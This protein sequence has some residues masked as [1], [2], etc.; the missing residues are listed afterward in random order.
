MTITES[1]LADRAAAAVQAGCKPRCVFKEQRWLIVHG[2]L[3]CY[4]SVAG[5]VRKKANPVIRSNLDIDP[6]VAPVFNASAPEQ[7]HLR[8][9]VVSDD[10]SDDFTDDSNS[11]SSTSSHEFRSSH[12]DRIS[13]PNL[14]R[15]RHSCG[16]VVSRRSCSRRSVPVDR[17][18]DV[19][20]VD[21]SSD[22]SV[23]V[24]GA[25]R[26]VNQIWSFGNLTFDHEDFSFL[27]KHF[28]C[29]DSLFCI[30]FVIIDVNSHLLPAISVDAHGYSS[31]ISCSHRSATKARKIA[32]DRSSAGSAQIALS[33]KY[34]T[35]ADFSLKF[36]TSVSEL[37]VNVMQCLQRGLLLLQHGIWSSSSSR[38]IFPL[39]LDLDALSSTDA[40]ARKHV[41]RVMSEYRPH[42]FFDFDEEVARPL[43]VDQILEL[44]CR[45]PDEH[46]QPDSAFLTPQDVDGISTRLKG[47]QQEAVAWARC[48][49]AGLSP[50]YRLRDLI[51]QP[52][53]CSI[54]NRKIFFDPVL[55]EAAA[56]ERD[57]ELLRI[58]GGMICDEM[59]LGKTLEC[60]ALIMLTRDVS[61]RN[62]ITPSVEYLKPQSQSLNPDLL[63][64]CSCGVNDLSNVVSVQCENCLY[65]L[66][67][68]C[69]NSFDSDLPYF[70]LSCRS[71]VRS[72]I[73]SE[74]TLIISPSSICGQ[75]I[76]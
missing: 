56:P 19:I 61:R 51:T 43:P 55:C 2:G 25:D 9:I 39:L 15:S 40:V 42:Q 46:V 37:S 5:M 58:S 24:I 67:V 29:S 13:E 17:G 72:P 18:L 8:R 63:Y 21:S 53:E 32:C 59:G 23:E 57:S 71:H 16:A 52:L 7:D 62:L 49:E 76:T 6:D 69:V 11:I 64:R 50:A 26:A 38:F 12:L 20:I 66:H 4:C 73:E 45:R 36:D 10:S 47:Y 1:W 31:G 34:A 68:K 33:S 48:V 74:S 27:E 54:T 30:A 44:I 28:D 70:C 75:V 35:F 14:K 3:F 65:W 41:N 22:E 60:L